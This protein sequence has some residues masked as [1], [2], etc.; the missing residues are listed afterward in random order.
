MNS[1]IVDGTSAYGPGCL[2]ALSAEARKR[3]AQEYRYVHCIRVRPSEDL[4]RLANDHL[5][6]GRLRGDPILTKRLFSVLDHGVDGEADLASYLLFDGPFCRRLIELG[7][8]DAQARRDELVQFFRGGLDDGGG[9]R[10]ESPDET[11]RF[12]R[13]S[14]TLPLGT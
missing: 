9:D 3:G 7:R 10:H 12:D 5:K 8:A 2:D 4:G 1:V 6:R 11:G 14:L 13:D